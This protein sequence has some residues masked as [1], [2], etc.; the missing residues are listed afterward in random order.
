MTRPT[1]ERDSRSGYPQELCALRR[2][3]VEKRLG[4][5]FRTSGST[6]W[7]KYLVGHELEVV[8]IAV[9]VH[10]LLEHSGELKGTEIKAWLELPSRLEF[11][12]LYDLF[13]KHFKVSLCVR[14][15]KDGHWESFSYKIREVER[16]LAAKKITL[17]RYQELS[18]QLA[19]YQDKAAAARAAVD[20]GRRLIAN[21]KA[22]YQAD[23]S[24]L[25]IRVGCGLAL[26]PRFVPEV[27]HEFRE[28]HQRD[29]FE[30]IVSEDV[31]KELRRHCDQGHYELVVTSFSSEDPAHFGDR[32]YACELPMHVLFDR[33]AA[34]DCEPGPITDESMFLRLV[35]GR[36]L[37]LPG[38]DRT[39]AL[40]LP[41]R[42]LGSAASVVETNLWFEALAMVKS[43]PNSCCIAFPQMFP[44][45]QRSRYKEFRLDLAGIPSFRLGVMRSPQNRKRHTDD[46]NKVIDGLL[47]TFREIIDRVGAEE[48]R[49]PARLGSELL[50]TAH[51]TRHADGH[52][53]VLGRIENLV[54][55]PDGYLRGTHELEAFDL[56][57]SINGHISI[58][59]A[60]VTRSSRS[61]S[62]VHVARQFVAWRGYEEK[63][64]DSNVK[65]EV[66][67]VSLS[68]DQVGAD[69]PDNL[70]L[71]GTW[72]GRSVYGLAYVGY[73]VLYSTTLHQE[74]QRD[75]GSFDKEGLIAELTRLVE[76]HRRDHELLLPLP[77][78]LR[79]IQAAESY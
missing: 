6:T 73:F 31:P 18:D 70:P 66:Y 22:L 58:A 52:Q 38:K 35:E 67:A 19:D 16:A 77:E 30:I 14:K 57:F 79:S 40:R 37:I 48:R 34:V 23:A 39:P 49:S 32:F 62:A 71:V 76:Q 60:R 59:P 17:K 15:K 26:V 53:W 65:K 25:V 1:R 41:A 9:I 61:Q 11:R 13:E 20:H 75:V 69:S 74:Y 78:K 47:N 55:T 68:R 27:V 46:E 36:R 10:Q 45:D 63:L 54:V 3:L 43:S 51:V 64:I 56:K 8:L 2:F 21:A 24:K 72:A 42:L 28:K 4:D 50:H 29:D 44:P 33:A 12:D 7:V 5:R